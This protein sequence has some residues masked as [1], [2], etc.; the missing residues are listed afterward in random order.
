MS[1]IF[2]FD[3]VEE[4]CRDGET[5]NYM[6][7]LQINRYNQVVWTRKNGDSEVLVMI[8]DDFIQ[9]VNVPTAPE[10]VLFLLS[11]TKEKRAQL[12]IMVESYASGQYI[13]YDTPEEH[14]TEVIYECGN[15]PQTR[16]Y[17]DSFYIGGTD[18]DEEKKHILQCIENAD[19]VF[20]K[21]TSYAYKQMTTE[22]IP[23]KVKLTFNCNGVMS[24]HSF[25]S[26][27]LHS[28]A[29][30]GKQQGE[31]G[32]IYVSNTETI[33]DFVAYS[34]DGSSSMNYMSAQDRIARFRSLALTLKDP[35]MKDFIDKLTQPLPERKTT[36]Y[37]PS[38]VASRMS[39]INY[40][41]SK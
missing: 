15:Q 2:F 6:L 7:N 31:H 3:K 25:V 19:V 14:G 21:K 24:S 16:G 22:N 37:N 40:L 39:D 38:D 27:Q 34:C 32:C 33:G 20:R 23:Y 28:N 35:Y 11:L 10:C 1:N 26:T 18:E 12:P 13:V 8:G 9:G 5:D 17:N 36:K 30:W 4:I 29:Y 41:L